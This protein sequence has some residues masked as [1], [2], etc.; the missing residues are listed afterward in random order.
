MQGKE[1]I[2]DMINTY[3]MLVAMITAVMAILGTCFMPEIKFGYEGFF[4]PLKYA[5]YATLP[6]MVMYSKKELNIRQFL[7]RK[8]LQLIL[9][10][11]IIITVAV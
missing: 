6:N 7:F 1:L 9:V 8:I 5:A 11:I 10:E 2:R 4:V 3:F